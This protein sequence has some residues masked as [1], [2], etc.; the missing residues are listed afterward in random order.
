MEQVSLWTRATCTVIR[1]ERYEVTKYNRRLGSHTFSQ[2]LSVIR[3][4]C[5]ELFCVNHGRILA[6][7]CM[8]GT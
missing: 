1:D 4:E 7:Y 6:V 2:V 8:L 5:G 3:L